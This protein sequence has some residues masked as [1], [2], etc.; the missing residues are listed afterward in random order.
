MLVLTGHTDRVRH[1]AFA[2]DGLSLV[3]CAGSCCRVWVWDLRT[4]K[5]HG[6][7][8]G[9]RARLEALAFAP[10][11]GRL[12]SADT[13]GTVGL[14]DQPARTPAHLLKAATGRHS[15]AGPGCLSFSPDGKT[16]ATAGI[17]SRFLGLSRTFGVRRWDIATA[18]KLPG[19]AGHPG[20]VL[21]VAHAPDGKALAS[22]DGYGVLQF[23][24]LSSCAVTATVPQ[25]AGIHGLAF[26][27]SGR[28]LVGI[29]GHFVLLWDLP[30][31]R[32]RARLESRK[33]RVWCMALSPDGKTLATAGNDATERLWD[34][35]AGRER[36]AFNWDIGKV[37]AV[38][39]AADG[40]R[41]AA[42]G[43]RN[44]VVWDVD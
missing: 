3:S 43:Q 15:L 34:V 11:G 22:G 20:R 26:T 33:H 5:S 23:W 18:K 27:P 2:P 35:D 12:A 7:M 39:F 17:I 19:L 37:Y 40:M 25:R 24:D 42:G 21:A 41:A 29:V 30:G 14:W 16:L 9:H 10:Q 31:V 44:I 6:W 13:A 8:M 4:G 38:A 28:T 32:L 1:L 36:A